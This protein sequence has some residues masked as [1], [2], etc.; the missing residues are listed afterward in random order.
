MFLVVTYFY[1]L[2]DVW[3]FI[4]PLFFSLVIALVVDDSFVFL[5]VS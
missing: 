5:L 4:I 1:D 3:K 2:D